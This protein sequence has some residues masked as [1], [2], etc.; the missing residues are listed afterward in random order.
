[1][2]LNTEIL[3]DFVKSCV[4]FKISMFRF[5]KKI[6]VQQMKNLYVFTYSNFLSA[7]TFSIILENFMFVKNVWV[8]GNFQ[9]SATNLT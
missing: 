3:K 9:C 8:D 7:E 1:M 6:M 4:L 5:F 2:I